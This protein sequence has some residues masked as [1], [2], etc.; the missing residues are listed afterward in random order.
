MSYEV[1]VEISVNI[2]SVGV[3]CHHHLSYGRI[4]LGRATQSG[5]L[6][7]EFRGLL[8][9]HS[10]LGVSVSARGALTCSFQVK[11][12]KSRSRIDCVS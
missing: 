11:K 8:S 5:L 3:I 2:S 1:D 12:Q 4:I 6:S 10:F 9:L 7:S